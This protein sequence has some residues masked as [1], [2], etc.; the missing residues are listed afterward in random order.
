M[1]VSLLM[2]QSVRFRVSL[3]AC[4]CERAGLGRWD[5]GGQLRPVVGGGRG[6]GAVDAAPRPQ[7]RVGERPVVQA[8]R[9]K[10]GQY[11]RH[12][13]ICTYHCPQVDPC[14]AWATLWHLR[15]SYVMKF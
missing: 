3:E 2:V 6:D 1:S 12:F 10:P 15:K 13:D 11:L 4:E 14:A 9:G 8:R 7:A 5:G